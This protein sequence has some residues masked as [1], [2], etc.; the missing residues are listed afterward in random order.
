MAEDR[1]PEQTLDY[2]ERA[3][4]VFPYALREDALDESTVAWLPTFRFFLAIRM[5]QRSNDIDMWRG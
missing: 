5:A 2:W 1:I 4:R 3:L